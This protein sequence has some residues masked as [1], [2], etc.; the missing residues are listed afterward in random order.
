[1]ALDVVQILNDLVSI[2]SVNPMGRDVQGEE[3]YEYRLT[4]YLQQLF[5]QLDLP[6]YRQNVGPKQDNIVALLE[7]E[8]P[9]ADGGPLVMLEAHQDTVPVEGM[10]IPPWT[11]QQRDG[12]IYGRGACDIKG[13]M[14]CMLATL[15]RLKEQSPA[16]IPS[17]LIACTVNEEHGFT[18]ALRLRQLWETPETPF[19]LRRP[20]AAI[21]VEPTQLNVVVAHKGVLR[22]RLNTRGRAAHSSRPAMGENAIYRMGHVLR[23]LEQYAEHILPPLGSHPLLGPA[24]LSVG[25]ITGGVSVNTVPD[26]CSIDIDRRLLPEEPAADAIR[27][28]REFLESEIPDA[29]E[30]Q[31]DEPSLVAPALSD[32]DNGALADQLCAVA[33]EIVNACHKIGVPYGTDAPCYAESGV[34]TVVF[35]PGSIEQAHTADEWV[36]IDQLHTATEIFHQF[37]LSSTV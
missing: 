31:H 17:V 35:G 32:R 15:S 26:R 22:W 3:Y 5:Q 12:R 25:L 16:R 29:L 36:S 23:A 1:M 19:P 6:W 4:D 10:T 7:G 37:I 24:S 33:G 8:I 20:D 30:I 34:P 11:P 21:V 14:A 9:L 27:H 28:L 13:G 18:G 2:P